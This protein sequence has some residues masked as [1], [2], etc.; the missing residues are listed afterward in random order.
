MA[1][2]VQRDPNYFRRL[3]AEVFGTFALVAVAAG[4]E[5]VAKVVGD[6]S[7]AARAVAPALLVMAMIYAIGNCS[8]AHFNPVVSLAFALRGAFPWETVPA[9]WLAQVVGAVLAGG[10]LRLVFPDAPDLGATLPHAGTG[11]ALAFE[12]FLTTLLVTV[13][14]GTATRHEL[15]GPNAAVAVGGTIALA[16]LIGG[17]VSGASMNPA[18]SLGPAVVGGTTQQLWIYFLGPAVGAVLAVLL[19]AVIHPH[20]HDGEHKAAGGDHPPQEENAS[21]EHVPNGRQRTDRGRN[22]SR[23]GTHH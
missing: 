23:R 12:V 14:L 22:R 11:A 16:G 18:R 7:P 1:N 20:K 10:F 5:V 4:G 6:V 2:E 13:A 21:D 19:T 9:Y 8:G 17:P 3:T 15:I